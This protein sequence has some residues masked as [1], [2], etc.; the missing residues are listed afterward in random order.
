M[1]WA[2]WVDEIPGCG[3]WGARCGFLNS[4][5]LAGGF[6]LNMNSRLNLLFNLPPPL[7]LY[8]I[9]HPLASS[10]RIGPLRII[11]NLALEV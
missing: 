8:P 10:E 3:H 9:P 6:N 1:H 5:G 7:I 2:Y 4:C 11:L